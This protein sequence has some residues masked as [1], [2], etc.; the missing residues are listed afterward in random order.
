[1]KKMMNEYIAEIEKKVKDKQNCD[2]ESLED[3]KLKISF[4]Q[5]ERLV[6]FLVTMLVGLITVI[7][8]VTNIFI[9]NLALL[10]LLVIF[11]L[12]LIPYLFHY[13]FLENKVQ[14]MYEL[15]DLMHKKMDKS[16]KS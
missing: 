3:L 14:Y 7:L 9:N 10:I 6:H 4:F 11:I 1:M 16:K 13:Y 2:E 8:L 12:L 5:H 15:Y